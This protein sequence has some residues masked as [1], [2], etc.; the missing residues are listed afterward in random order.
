MPELQIKLPLLPDKPIV[1]ETRSG[2]KPMTE[3]TEERK[4]VFLE[5]LAQ[6][7]TVVDAAEAAGITART[8]FLHRRE[9]AEF[10][11]QWEDAFNAGVAVLEREAVRRATVGVQEP[12]LYKG[13]VVHHVTKYSDTLLQFLLRAHKPEMY[14]ERKISEVTGKNGGPVQTEARTVIDAESLTP[15]QREALRTALLAARGELEE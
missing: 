5:H 15:D 1:Y 3:F 11:K 9:D 7:P 2:K 6:Y 10:A 12:M 8:A 4:R 13:E 14:T